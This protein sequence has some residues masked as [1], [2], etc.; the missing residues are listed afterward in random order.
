MSVF[1][2]EKQ[3]F[4]KNK[5]SNFEDVLFFAEKFRGFDV[6]RLRIEWH[7]LP[8]KFGAWQELDMYPFDRVW[9][10]VIHMWR[11]PKQGI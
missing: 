6:A 7:L 10:T 11:V 4:W 9:K 2:A 1:T 3:F 5:D 8:E